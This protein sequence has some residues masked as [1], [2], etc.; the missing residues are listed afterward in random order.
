MVESG[1]LSR[2][3]RRLNTLQPALSKSLRLLEEQLGVRLL[4]RGPR[5]VRL[6]K[7]G[8]SFY[9]RAADSP[10]SSVARARTSRI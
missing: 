7:F 6:T 3:A 1:S 8:D 5:G 4:E 10:P 2:T 9:R